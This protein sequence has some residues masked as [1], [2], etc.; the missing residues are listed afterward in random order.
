MQTARSCKALEDDYKRM[1][2]TVGLQTLVEIH[3]ELARDA[4]RR[5]LV[6]FEKEVSEVGGS[7]AEQ[8]RAT[9]DA[10]LESLKKK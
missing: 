2:Q 8:V 1:R 7:F 5:H 4:V 3:A 6:A 9:T 10:L